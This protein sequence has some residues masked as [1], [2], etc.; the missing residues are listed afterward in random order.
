VNPTSDPKTCPYVGLDPFESAHANYFFGRNRESKIIADHILARPVTVLFGASGTGKSSILNVGVPNLLKQIA[1]EHQDDPK[2]TPDDIGSYFV[3]KSQRDWQDPASAA[4]IIRSWTTETFAHPVLVFLDQFEEYFL[5]ADQAHVHEFGQTLHDLLA[6]NDVPVHL[7]FGLRDD[8]LHRL[9]QLR[10]YIPAILDTTI[11]LRGLTDA[12]VREAIRGPINRYNEDFRESAFA[13]E[14]EDGLVDRLVRQLK[15][16]D[17]RHG[18]DRASSRTDRPIEL[19]YLQLALTKIWAAEGGK[20]ATILHESTLVG[21]L[22]GVSTIVRDHVKGVMSTL[23]PGEQTLCA[24]MFDRLVTAIGGKI[25]YPTAALATEAVL[26]QHLDRQKIEA[27]LNKLTTTGARILKPVSIN[28]LDGF[29]LFHDVLG[30]PVLEWKQSFEARQKEVKVRRLA[31]L[32]RLLAVLLVAIFVSG[33]FYT[34]YYFII[35]YYSR[36]FI[37]LN[38]LT[39]TAE[40]DLKAGNSFTEC[41]VGCPE[42]V[43]V[44]AN[45]FRMGSLTGVGPTA[46]E[47]PPHTVTI[48]R[49]FAVSKFAVTFEQWDACA[50]YGDCYKKTSD[51]GYGRGRQP[52][53]NVSWTDAKTYALWLTKMTGKNYRL[54]SEAEYEYAARGGTQTTYPWGP[55]F[56]PGKAGC[57][58]CGGPWENK[59]APV[60]SFPP[61]DFGLYDMLGNVLEWVEDCY[62]ANYNGAPSDGSAWTSGDCRRRVGRG[63]VSWMTD[64]EDISKLHV[65]Q[66][67]F[68]GIDFIGPGLGFRVARTLAP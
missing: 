41:K 58:A 64:K 51:D 36:S 3:V 46:D 32:V 14:V 4:Q 54:L 40:R 6:R 34:A 23:A 39:D 53:I 17:N 43:V 8:G 60:G 48:P 29:E 21:R 2:N 27:T 61:N 12:G 28:G 52:V 7:I 15:E 38:L 49:P 47:G 20:N 26:G 45:P 10:A 11:E 44:P 1:K 56:L 19:P 25:A 9:D 57:K 35:Q 13:I 62:Q 42:M 50:T 22:G 16:A 68:A 63:S 18:I 33:T 67:R 30:L 37:G 24:K 59:P 65:T 31:R 5:Y 55:E 66:R